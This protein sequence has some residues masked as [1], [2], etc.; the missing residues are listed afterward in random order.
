MPDHETWVTGMLWVVPD[1]REKWS[2]LAKIFRPFL[3]TNNA[4]IMPKA[5]F[6]LLLQKAHRTQIFFGILNIFVHRRSKVSV[7]AAYGNISMVAHKTWLI[8]NDW[9]TIMLHGYTLF[10]NNISRHI[11]YRSLFL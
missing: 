3:A 5:S 4:K 8:S 7:Q 2:L 11:F 6:C 9:M 1:V 10:E